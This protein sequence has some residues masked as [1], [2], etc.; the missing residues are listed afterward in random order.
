M[1]HSFHFAE[2]VAGL[3]R[4]QVQL[5]GSQLCEKKSA[6]LLQ[7]FQGRLQSLYYSL[8]LRQTWHQELKSPS[9]PSA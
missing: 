8:L 2:K 6:V 4:H 3:M 1:K 5:E 7:R 9:L